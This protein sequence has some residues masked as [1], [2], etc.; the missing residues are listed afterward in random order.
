MISY[1]KTILIGLMLSNFL[2]AQNYEIKYDSLNAYG[3][4]GGDNRPG[5][6]RNVAVAQSVTIEKPVN[7][8]SF[9]F[10]FTAPFDSAINK[11]GSGIEVNLRLH[12]RDS[13]G[14]VKKT[15]DVVVPDTFSNGWVTWEN[16]NLNIAEPGKY[17]FSTY[18][19]GGY[20][21]VK[22]T[23][24]QGCDPDSGYSGGEMFAK[25]VVSDSDAAVW[26]D[27]SLS[28]WDSDFWLIAKEITTNA[29]ENDFNPEN[30]YLE[31]NYPNPFNPTTKIKYRIPLSPPLVKGESEAG[32]FVTLKIYDIL[33]REVA[34][35][36][37]EQKQPGT[38][39]VEFTTN[40][41]TNNYS[42]FPSGVYFY[43][44]KIGQYVQTKKLVLLK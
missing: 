19:V 13:I 4:F 31:Q 39:E 36:V 8:S 22:L 29:K 42:P 23:S 34:T 10:R 21:S 32:R 20:D 33:G 12:I 15:E 9:A 35:L 16:I 7:L 1:I 25:Y 26:S 44:L 41:G 17:I 6:Q 3:W 30:F 14:A 2:F 38:Y 5:H 11:T 37:N 18:L 28:S 27:W 40:V 24:S 43:Q